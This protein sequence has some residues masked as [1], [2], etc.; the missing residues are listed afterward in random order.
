[1]SGVKLALATVA[2]FVALG[3]ATPANASTPIPWCVTNSS[4]ADRAPEAT[5]AFSVHVAYVRPPGAPD[6]FAEFAPRVVGDAAAFDAWWRREDATRTPRFDLFPAPGCAS[7]FGSLDLSN[8]Q[9]TQPTGGISGA[10]GSIRRQLAQL[11]FD[12][13]EKAYLVYFDGSTGQSGDERV[14]GQGAAPSG[15]GAGMAV[16][17]LD[18]CF[19]DEGDD[20][21]PVTALH[22]LIHVMGAVGRAAPNACQ[23]GHVCDFPLDLMG[24]ELTGEPLDSHVLDSG[25][26]DYYGHSGTWTDVQDSTFLERLDSPDRTPPTTPSGLI[27][28]DDPRG[29]VRVSWQPATDDVGPVVYRLYEDGE[30]VREVKTTSVLL[31]GTT[32][33][34]RYSVRAA[35]TVG[36]L[37]L[38]SEARFRPGLGMVDEQGRL[39]RDTVRPPAIIRVAV[40]KLAKTVVLSWPAVRDGGGLRGY[41]VKF[42]GR[43]LSVSKPTVV[44]ARSKLVGAVSISAVD[45]AGNAGPA[46][47]VSRGRLR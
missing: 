12:E 16:V 41:R 36:R 8:V 11:G 40:R 44:I 10:F 38:A 22:E 15:F 39:V 20:L 31:P 3:A 37:G 9:L 42:G 46:L 13:A 14:C 2:A 45:R 27:V 47:V 33:T 32:A 25:R 21:R 5:L 28:A 29:S 7:T 19:A 18:S 24:A 35:D 43:T 1:L 23:S 4:A 17:Y 30:F 26:N 34:V 6:R